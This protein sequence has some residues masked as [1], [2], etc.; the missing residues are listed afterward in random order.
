MPIKPSSSENEQEFIGR[1]M[2]IETKDY[3]SDQAYAICKSKWDSE[4]MSKFSSP[5]D[6][7]NS[8][9]N[10]IRIKKTLMEKFGEN[11]DACWEGYIQVGTKILDGREVPDCRGPVDLE[12]GVPHYTKDG[13]LWE[14]P[15]HMGPDGR[16][17]TGEVHTE[18]SEYLYH[19]EELEAMPTISSTYPGES[20]VTG[21]K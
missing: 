21:S 6:R 4:N 12:Q 7:V 10:S 18:D 11:S 8:K 2:S 13:K 1:C 20:S 9:F 3:P 17:M 15:T 19:S 14:G 16:L 5:Y